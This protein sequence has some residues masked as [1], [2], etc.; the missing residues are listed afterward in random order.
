MLNI[1]AFER[2]TNAESCGLMSLSDFRQYR[3]EQR[4]RFIQEERPILERDRLELWRQYLYARWQINRETD[5]QRRKQMQ[6]ALYAED[7]IAWRWA[8]VDAAYCQMGGS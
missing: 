1:P 5:S 6:E 8:R 4:E 2:E 7:G 3:Q